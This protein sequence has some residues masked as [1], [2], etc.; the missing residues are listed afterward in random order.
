[1]SSESEAQVITSEGWVYQVKLHETWAACSCKRQVICGHSMA[2]IFKQ[3]YSLGNYLPQAH[4]VEQ[5]DRQYRGRL[6]IIVLDELKPNVLFF[7]TA[8]I[9]R[10]PRG[11]PR[12]ERIRTDTVRRRGRGLGLS[13]MTE[14][15]QIAVAATR[16]R[17]QRHCGTCGRTGHD[18]R[19]CRSGHA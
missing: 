4:T 9:T 11:R 7:C 2:V 18:S 3:G 14:D 1:M 6:R 17:Q 8:P 10:Q 16:Q 13:E 12:K 19:R 15:L 5:W